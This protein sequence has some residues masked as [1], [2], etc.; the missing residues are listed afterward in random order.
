MNILVA[1]V[2]IA[3]MAFLLRFAV[4]LISEKRKLTKVKIECLSTSGSSTGPK[5]REWPQP[6][7]QASDSEERFETQEND[8]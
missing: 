3:S 7:H 2:C 5:G 1:L 8:Q 4:A 6:V